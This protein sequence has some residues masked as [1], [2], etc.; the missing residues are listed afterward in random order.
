MPPGRF[1][2][3]SGAPNSKCRAPGPPVPFQQP[4][5]TAQTP[6]EVFVTLARSAPRSSN[7]MHVHALPA[8]AQSG[9][10]ARGSS[11]MFP[12]REGMCKAGY[13]HKAT[14][15]CRMQRQQGVRHIVAAGY[16]H[17]RCL[18]AHNQGK[19]HEAVSQCI[20]KGKHGSIMQLLP[21]APPALH[22]QVCQVSEC[23]QQGVQ[24]AH[25]LGCS[26]ILILCAYMHGGPAGQQY[27]HVF[28]CA[29]STSRC[30]LRL[31]ALL[32]SLLSP[33]RDGQDPHGPLHMQ[34]EH[35]NSQAPPHAHTTLH[36]QHG[37]YDSQAPPHAYAH[38]AWTERLP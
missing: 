23:A 17:A 7:E 21:S 38:V 19:K 30:M 4:S 1:A 25:D 3:V 6:Q 33:S 32:C 16:T 27:A 13:R 8:G 10:E 11:S 9:Q 36:M 34:H 15:R 2:H 28:M 14:S 26:G 22:A 18:Q 37:R 24:S 35:R 29:H 20:L 5:Q 31:A 12:Q